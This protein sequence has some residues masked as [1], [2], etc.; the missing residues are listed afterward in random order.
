M[1]GLISPT[2]L[3]C[4][5][6]DPLWHE[7]YVAAFGGQGGL[8]CEG[9]DEFG[10][11]AKGCDRAGNRA[12]IYRYHKAYDE[13]DFEYDEGCHQ[14]QSAWS[15]YGVLRLDEVLVVPMAHQH[16]ERNA[17]DFNHASIWDSED[18]MFEVSE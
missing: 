3:K 10:Y 18:G 5:F 16:L 8:D 15:Q 17:R 14:F 13:D 2:I 1:R 4:I 7:R 11:D 12:D 6:C 9:Y